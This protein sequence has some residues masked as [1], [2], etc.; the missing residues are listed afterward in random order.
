MKW[1]DIPWNPSAKSLRQFAGA[2]L[3]FLG[4]TGA[5]QWLARG[6]ERRGQALIAVALVIGLPGLV[7]PVAV[8]WLFVA[9]LVLT[10]PIGWAVSQLML[11]VM[12]YLVITPVAVFFR[13]RG[14]DPLARKPAPD[15]ASFWTE[16]SL[17]HDVRSYF[18]QH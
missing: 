3:V 15:R 8:R 9:A 5:H 13:L 1:S 10:F 11:A 14:R 6:H 16:K 18:R 4:A 17:P 2:W 7:K 12:F